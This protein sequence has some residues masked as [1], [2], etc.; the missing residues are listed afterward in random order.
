MGPI[1]SIAELLDM[2]RRRKLVIAAV[3]VLGSIGSLL[4]AAA[5]THLY[6]SSEVLQVQSPRIAA[7]LAPSTIAGSAARRLQLIEQQVMSRGAIL[8]TIDRLGLFADQPGLRTAEMV[9]L[10][11]QSVFVEGV[12][13]AREGFADDGSVSLLRVN[14]NWPTA[15]GAQALAHEFSQRTIALSVS[16]RLDQARETLDFFIA[17]EAVIT[18]DIARES[19]A[20]AAYR[21]THDMALPGS[22][23]LMQREVES[24]TEGLLS[25]DRQ[26]ITLQRDLAQPA[27][28]RIERQ[29]RED[30]QAQIAQL[31]EERA[32]LQS[33][34]A[35]LTETLQASPEVTVQIA[36][37]ERRIEDLRAQLQDVT[38][39]RKE[40]EVSY[41]LETTSQSERLTVLEPAPL[42]DYPYTRSRKV[43]ALMGA[44][45]ALLLGV[46]VAFLMD[47]RTPIIRTADQMERELGLRPVISI[48][49]MRPVRSPR[50]PKPR[51]RGR[52][53]GLITALTRGRR[54]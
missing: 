51:K 28:T 32:L 16:T 48:P 30:T 14:A 23:D 17:Q 3:F 54:L 42:P 37:Y 19:A 11:R 13:A 49:E 22:I 38:A 7:E 27:T 40:A 45:A 43:T 50:A 15:R 47:W 39:R 1:H 5:Q 25:I 6:T 24:L 29:Q 36:Q 46:A 4:F 18:A 34:L 41:T 53:R 31:S 52:L 20:L 10:V 9:A 21:A 26:L 44:L 2:L 12:A 35:G 33:N 8:E